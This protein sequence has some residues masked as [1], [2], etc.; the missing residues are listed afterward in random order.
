MF[1]FPGQGKA[2]FML[3]YNCASGVA[4]PFRVEELPTRKTKMRK[5]LRKFEETIR[6]LQEM[7]KCCGY[8]LILPTRWLTTALT[9]SLIDVFL[10]WICAN[11]VY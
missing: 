3:T 2:P 10:R 1:G 9:V 6:K 4:G 5:K 8:I 11:L 7:R